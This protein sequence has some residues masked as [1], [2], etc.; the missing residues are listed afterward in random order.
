[1][2]FVRQNEDYNSPPA[3][4]DFDQPKVL[5]VYIEHPRRL[6]DL[7]VYLTA[8]YTHQQLPMITS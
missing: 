6:L 3:A 7:N 8:K 1:M 4:L 5:H 2:F